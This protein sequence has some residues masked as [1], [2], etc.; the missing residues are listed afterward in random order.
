MRIILFLSILSFS[1]QAQ[2]ISVEDS[3]KK[4][5][6]LKVSLK[7][8]DSQTGQFLDDSTWVRIINLTRGDLIDSAKV[9][10]GY[11][12]FSVEKGYKYGISVKRRQ[13]FMEKVSFDM[14]CNLEDPTK[15]ICLT[16]AMLEGMSE[17]EDG[18]RYIESG[19][20]M[21]KIVINYAYNAENLY[22]DTGR[23]DI[24][25]DAARELD[26]LVRLLRD[27][28]EIEIEL[29]SHT[30]SRGDDESNLELSQRRADAAIKY[31]VE[32]GGVDKDRISGIGYGETKPTNHCY[33]GVRCS[34]SEY[35]KNRRTEV[36]ITR[37]R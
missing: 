8:R 13:Y 26:K 35:Q 31:I 25:P 27:N 30:D 4:S 15:T 2:N 5:N 16:G 3:P 7:V 23:A 19:V 22:Y 9:D 17:D 10:A 24:R 1:I 11:A 34:E 36:K 6:I 12:T 37:V 21:K 32:T 20:P 14:M 29:S 33:N 18:T 28:P